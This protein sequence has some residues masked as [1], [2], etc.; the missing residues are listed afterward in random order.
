MARLSAQRQYVEEKLSEWYGLPESA[1]LGGYSIGFVERDKWTVEITLGLHPNAQGW[2]DPDTA[3]LIQ[4]L[5][6][7]GWDTRYI[8]TG[9][10][11]QGG[12]WLIP[13]EKDRELIH[14]PKK[15]FDDLE[16]EN[17]KQKT[18]I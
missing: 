12:L 14:R 17:E 2:E 4:E 3:D 11:G 6:D 10:V 15:L 1:R 8:P 7:L 16:T 9:T 13:P 18:G 5:F